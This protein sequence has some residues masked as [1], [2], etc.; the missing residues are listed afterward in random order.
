MN[1]WATFIRG[2]CAG[3]RAQFALLLGCL[4]G[5]CGLARK[6]AARL[7]R[8]A[9]LHSHTP[10]LS[11]LRTCPTPLIDGKEGGKEGRGGEG[12][13]RGGEVRPHST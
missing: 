9:T 11:V 2:S 8:P 10:L 5:C 13:A 6:G 3:L 4:Q 1:V 7:A 12:S